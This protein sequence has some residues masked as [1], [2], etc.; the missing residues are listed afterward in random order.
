M[1]I[2]KFSLF[3]LL[4]TS[5]SV[6]AEVPLT[7]VDLV[8]TW[9]IDKESSNKDGSPARATNTIWNV[10][11]DGTIEGVTQESDAHA[12]VNNIKAVL[13][14]SIENGKLIKQA[15]PGRSK[16]ET[17]EA[18]E[19]NGNQMVLKCQTVYFFMSKK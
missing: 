5:F 10:K 15:A 9:Q 3:A 16:M 13:N 14:Y 8:G 12:R 4:F 6:L 7:Q 17:C 18:I 1:H 19:K 2:Q 11:N